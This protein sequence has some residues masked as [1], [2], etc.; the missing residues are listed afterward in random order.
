MADNVKVKITEK[1]GVE[2]PY[3]EEYNLIA[4]NIPF[5]NTSNG[6][7]STDVQDAIEEVDNNNTNARVSIPLLANSTV[8]NNQWV[9]YSELIPSNTTP[10]VLP[11]NCQMTNI[12][13]ANSNTSVDGIFEIYKNGLLVANR[14]YQWQFTNSNNTN[15]LSLTLNFVAGD[16]L[17]FKWVDQG[18]NPA[19]AV[20]VLFFTLS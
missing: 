19:D 12:S 20:W 7:I 14:I 2:L 17:S 4:N 5:D 8:S 3:D 16:E 18:T 6:F 9:G 11:W 15:Y 1:N 13:F 10:I